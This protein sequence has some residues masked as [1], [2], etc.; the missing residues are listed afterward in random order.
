MQ[1]ENQDIATVLLVEDDETHAELV[2]RCFED[3]ELAR[4]HWVE[5]GREALDYLFQRGKHSD[6]VRP[7]LILLD[8]RLPKTGGHEV[9]QRI[10]GCDDL[11]CIPVVVLTT[12]SN[13]DDVMKAYLYHANS[14]IVKP[15]GFDEF[16]RTVKDVGIYWLKRNL[17]Y[18]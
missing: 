4:V 6:S 9:L 13:K 8:L 18:R 12:S 3:L 5:D 7:D 16:Y 15:I 2:M 10:K 1:S 11:R 17:G 14:Y